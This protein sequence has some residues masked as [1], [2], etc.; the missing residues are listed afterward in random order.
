MMQVSV[1]QAKTNLQSWLGLVGVQPNWAS[2]PYADATF[3]FICAAVVIWILLEFLFKK[4]VAVSAQQP[5]TQ[6]T[7]TPQTVTTISSTNQSGGIT[8]QN[9]NTLQFGKRQR[10]I[11]EQWKKDFNAYLKKERKI[12]LWVIESDPEARI[13]AE[14]IK[15][16]L[17]SGGFR[18][19]EYRTQPMSGG[20]GMPEIHDNPKENQMFILIGP[21]FDTKKPLRVEPGL[22]VIHESGVA[23]DD[24]P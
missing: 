18:Y 16:F 17:I 5:T 11:T 2:S 10:R 12:V 15:T 23:K 4:N 8:A 19:D 7:T 20:R 13:L 21:N 1:S 24:N 14:E 3:S 6:V 22:T 9:V